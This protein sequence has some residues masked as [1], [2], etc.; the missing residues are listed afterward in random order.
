MRIKP[1]LKE[2]LKLPKNKNLIVFSCRFYCD[3]LTPLSIYYN[4]RRYIKK[5]SFLLESVE[6]EEKISRYSFL[7]FEPLAVFK[8]Y[9][10]RV[11]YI[12]YKEGTK[13]IF[14]KKDPL[15]ELKK[16]MC[17]FKVWPKKNLR[18]FGG[19]VG[20]LGYDFVRFCEPIG[21]ELCDK[22]NT[23]D[24]Y[25]ILPRYLIIFDH[26]KKEIELLSFFFLKER[27]SLR[28][29]NREVRKLKNL[30]KKIFVVRKL[31]SLN[32][33][34]KKVFKIKSNFTKKDFLNAVRKAKRYIR[35]GEIIQVVLS[36][37][38]W[39]SFK[40][41]PFLVYRYLRLLNP[42]PYMYYLDFANLK[43]VGASPEMLLRCEKHFLTTRPIAGTRKRG[44]TEEEDIALEKELI[45]DSKERA[46]H[47]ML[48]DLAR[49][50]LGR[51]AQPATVNV[52]VFMSVERFSHVMH[53]VS[54]V[55][56]HLCK[57]FDMFD[58]LRACF[59]AG[60]VTGAPK[61]RAMQI[62]NE[63]EPDRRGIYAG[64]VGYFSFTKS[65]DTCIIIRTIVFNNGYAYIQAGAGIVADS[66]PE[67]EFRE[68]LNKAKA[69]LLA[70]R[71]ASS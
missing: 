28:I 52:P 29:Y 7:G 16:I 32:W 4:L 50:D 56:A 70:L 64:C 36:Q 38:L 15:E 25:F 48:V 11:S 49:N 60:T 68:T 31:P 37:R 61:V 46:E 47:I 9:K 14:C 5:E 17:N 58:A 41:D 69:Q 26:I 23:P 12:S 57:K 51:V 18:F 67:R 66:S 55:R 3:W 54:E 34:K 45:S 44:V 21:S 33:E 42:S 71:M 19:F 20:Y 1:S 10:N 2:F 62:I 8:S 35:E 39:V 59:P 27:P 53:I 6:G 22:I 30:L 40:K 24:C 13:E 63:L 65:L 43:I